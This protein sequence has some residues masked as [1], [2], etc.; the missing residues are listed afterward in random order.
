MYDELIPEFIEESKSSL[1]SIEADLLQLESDK[2]VS[3]HY[4]NRVF[5]AMYTFQG[6]G[7]VYQ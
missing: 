1:A 7:N 2:S 3:V 4:V 5:R 6:L